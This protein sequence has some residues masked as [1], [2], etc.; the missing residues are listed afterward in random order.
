M[1]C[2]P[3]ACPSVDYLPMSCI[4]PLLYTRARSCNLPLLY[5]LTRS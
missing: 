5:N 2:P 1:A 4:L 3:V